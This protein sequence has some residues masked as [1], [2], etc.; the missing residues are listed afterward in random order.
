M[1]IR[2]PGCGA[3]LNVPDDRAGQTGRCPRCRQ[4][5][6]IVA[7]GEEGDAG[8]ES[9]G[10]VMPPIEEAVE[11]S[12]APLRRRT[13]S[14]LT[15]DAG[16]AGTAT[17]ADSETATEQ[18][19]VRKKKKKKKK[20]SGGDLVERLASLKSWQVGGLA[21][22]AIA[23]VLLGVVLVVN[24]LTPA[25]DAAL[26]AA[27][28]AP[29]A[30]R[31][32]DDH[33]K[34]IR[35]GAAGQA[36][37]PGGT[38]REQVLASATLLTVDGY[39]PN[40]DAIFAVAYNA[41]GLSPQQM[42]MKPHELLNDFC[43]GFRNN[44]HAQGGIELSRRDFRVG[45]LPAV[46]MI[47][48]VPVARGKLVHRSILAGND[49]YVVLAG[50]KGYRPDHP[51]IQRFLDSF[52]FHAAGSPQP[53]AP[54]VAPPAARPAQA[55]A[56][57]GPVADAV[58]KLKQIGAAIHKYES[59]NKEFP[60]DAFTDDRG[61]P[62]LSWRVAILPHLG[63]NDLYEQFNFDEPWNG[64]HNRR[65]IAKMPDVF[66]PAGLRPIPRGETPF[67]ALVGPGAIFDPTKAHKA[68]EVTDGLD[69][70][71]IVVETA[72]TV[73]WTKPE[74]LDIDGASPEFGTRY[75]DGFLALSADGQVYTLPT[76]VDRTKLRAAATR[77]GGEAGTIA[78]LK[79]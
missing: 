8:Q 17:Q 50:G 61:R 48:R 38:Q 53:A 46:E 62:L 9:R 27:Y 60:P 52:E 79:P 54:P 29:P 36:L 19:A 73:P 18:P 3:R 66:A 20:G 40:D 32:P 77:A 75:D 41:K 2:C 51:D 34:P 14:R 5:I 7:E 22:G 16:T 59:T 45:D 74:G 39:K 56:A 21:L 72:A 12:E 47:S 69:K 31:I 37:M 49:L 63:H 11:A 44:V 6:P 13:A 42:N 4:A 71:L 24:V 23:A 15:R 35:F 57:H 30:K 78:E 28:A 64:P 58:A 67:Q 43:D 1:K 70:T 76:N 10:A 55:E 26:D 33:W 25:V 65:L 68:T